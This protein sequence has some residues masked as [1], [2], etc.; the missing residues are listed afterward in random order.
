MVTV[1]HVVDTLQPTQSL[2]LLQ[3]SPLSVSFSLSVASLRAWQGH[4]AVSYYKRSSPSLLQETQTHQSHVP[5]PAAP[6][7][8]C[9][10]YTLSRWAFGAEEEDT[11][12]DAHIE[13]TNT[14]QQNLE[15]L[16]CLP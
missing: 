10:N 12:A 2:P 16:C 4:G 13:W 5:T 15:L 11:H 8:H 3:P 6:A 14:K 1:I 7:H 9:F